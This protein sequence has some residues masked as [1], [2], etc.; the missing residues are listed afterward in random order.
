MNR[1]VCRAVVE[2]AKTCEQE[3]WRKMIIFTLPYLHESEQFKT[4]ET[5]KA[6]MM[7]MVL[8]MTM[9][10]MMT[11]KT[12]TYNL[13]YLLTETSI[14]TVRKWLSFHAFYINLV[15]SNVLYLINEILLR[16]LFGPTNTV[17]NIT[18]TMSDN[19]QSVV[20]FTGGVTLFRGPRR[21]P[22]H[23]VT[24]LHTREEFVSTNISVAI[25]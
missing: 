6:L 14:F 18:N 9:I 3:K 22:L 11:T 23:Y 2:E 7:V 24:L 4:V 16:I 21:N 12:I 1:M 25:T 5:C 10:K 15:S 19:S 13:R 17:S 8:M 20:V